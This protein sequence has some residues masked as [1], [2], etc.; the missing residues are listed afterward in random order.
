MFTQELVPGDAFIASG[1]SYTVASI[2]DDLNLT[3]A[4]PVVSA[5][6]AGTSITLSKYSD[7]FVAGSEPFYEFNC[8]DAAYDTIGRIRLMVRD[9]DRDFKVTD[10]I[11]QL[12]V[13]LTGT[14]T[15]A[16]STTQTG[17][18]T[19]FTTEVIDKRMIQVGTEVNTVDS[20]ATD[21]SLEFT[22]ASLGL[23]TTQNAYIRPILSDAGESTDLFS[24][25]YNN[26]TDWDDDRNLYENFTLGSFSSTESYYPALNTCGPQ[27]APAAPGQADSPGGDPNTKLR[28]YDYR[29]P[30][31]KL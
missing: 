16:A 10:R 23:N 17:T 2:T 25:F 3:L 30:N 29:F 18:G 13:P 22:T 20:I 11:D 31:D 8:L 5:V 15:T 27:S 19:L 28:L 9:W 26:R 24:N 14:V 6:A 21:T 12:T 4:N 7:P 1:E